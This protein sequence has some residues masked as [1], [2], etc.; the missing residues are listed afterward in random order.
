MLN[1]NKMAGYVKDRFHIG[2]CSVIRNHTNRTDGVTSLHAFS[3][4]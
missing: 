1:K 2:S 4:R 3:F